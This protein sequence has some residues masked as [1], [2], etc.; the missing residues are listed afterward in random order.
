M[1]VTQNIA[2]VYFISN[3]DIIFILFA[4]D[5]TEASLRQVHGH[6][7]SNTR[8]SE[9]WKTNMDSDMICFGDGTYGPCSV[10]LPDAK[11]WGGVK[12]GVKILQKLYPS[13]KK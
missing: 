12:K 4:E 10:S 2:H 6:V 7:I 8:C 5:D 13:S 3:I 1:I 11:E 9:Y